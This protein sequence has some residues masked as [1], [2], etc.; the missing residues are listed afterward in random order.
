MPQEPEN[1]PVGDQG[2]GLP[3]PEDQAALDQMFSGGP[4]D[5]EDGAAA[6][7]ATPTEK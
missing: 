3:S 4:V 6:L 7:G 2:F 1:E 5:F